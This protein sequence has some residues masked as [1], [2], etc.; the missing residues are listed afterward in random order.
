MLEDLNV[1]VTTTSNAVESS[2]GTYCPGMDPPP[3]PE[4]M[5]CLGDL[6]SVAWME[7]S[8]NHNLKEETVGK[9]YESV[10]MRTSNQNTYSA[11]SHVMEYDNKNVKPEKLYLYQGF[12]PANANLTENALRLS[13]QMGVINQRDADLLFLWHMKPENGICHD[14]SAPLVKA[15]TIDELHSLQKKRSA[16]TTPIK[17]GAQQGNAAFATISEEERQK[18][19]LQ[20]IRSIFNLQTN[21]SFSIIKKGETSK[22]H[23]V[24]SRCL[25]RPFKAASCHLV[26]GLGRAAAE[27]DSAVCVE[28]RRGAAEEASS[29]LVGASKGFSDSIF[30]MSVVFATLVIVRCSGVCGCLRRHGYFNFWGTEVLEELR[31]TMDQFIDL[32]ILSDV[33]IVIALKYDNACVVEYGACAATVPCLCY[34]DL[35]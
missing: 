22:F 28:F 6:Y 27:D 15:K 31:L 20:S 21:I 33:I 13:K 8:E 24:S 14:D 3:P 2:W 12:D 25:P 23:S 30:A 19:Q 9:Q 16:P 1:Y 5:T 10:K 32:C 7:D 34:L 17:D 11:G 26:I 35:I 29:R 18:L 4:Y